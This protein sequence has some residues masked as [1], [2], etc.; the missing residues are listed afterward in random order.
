[1]EVKKKVKILHLEDNARDAALL[2]DLLAEQ[3]FDCAIT[4]VE[5]EKDF[6]HHLRSEEFD[7]VISDFTIPSY[8]G[9]QALD[10]SH[11][12]RPDTPFVFFS[13]T[14]GEEVAVESLQRG[15]TDYVLK[16]KVHRLVPAIRRALVVG[17]ERLRRKQAEQEQERLSAQLLRTQRLESIGTLAGGIAHDLNNVL[18]PILLSVQLIRKKVA[19]ESVT[20]LLDVVEA[21]ANRGADMVKQVLTF[22]RGVEGQRSVLDIG[23]LIEEI[24]KIAQTTF[25][26]SIQ[27]VTDVPEDL[28]RVSADAT[29]MYQVVMNLC[30]NARDAMAAGG[31]LRVSAENMILD[32][33]YAQMNAE[34]KAGPHIVI[35]VSDTGAGIP[36][37]IIERIF[38]PFFTTKEVGKGT[39]LGLSTVQTIV[40]NHHGFIRVYSESGRGTSFNLFLPAISTPETIE[41]GRVGM[42]LPGGHNELILIVDD[43][44]SIREIMKETL[45]TFGYNILVAGDGTEAVAL[46]AAHK[47]QIKAVITD[48]AM[49]IMD[50]SATI[51]A[52][53]KITPSLRVIVSSGLPEHENDQEALQANAF[54][55]KPFTAQQLLEVLQRVLISS[56][57]A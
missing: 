52:L 4:R 33:Q 48:M 6:H 11:D 37:Q 7:V 10:M 41:R 51:R 20:K 36:R 29:Q 45:E 40:K 3:G 42:K 53:R 25:P 24:S 15:A 13:G 22:A 46:Y 14:I 35:K 12:L 26:K 50:G 57:S 55:H 39:G 19:E 17:E 27:T 43:E 18:G 5:T 56:V 38:D 28:W 54:L 49:P 16:S 47:D 30:V 8:N 44:A 34:A 21:A 1:M 32:D 31:T 2:Q 9:M 23:R